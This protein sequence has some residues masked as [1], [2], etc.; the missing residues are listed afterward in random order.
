MLKPCVEF[1]QETSAGLTTFLL[2]NSPAYRTV[3]AAL[4][5]LWTVSHC[6]PPGATGLWRGD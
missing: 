2:E 3:L 5:V 4:I 1:E 6:H